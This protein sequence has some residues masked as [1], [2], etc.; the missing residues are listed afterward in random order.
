MLGSAK[1]A[2]FVA[3][4][5][6]PRARAFYEGTLGLRVVT[7]DQF[8]IAFDCDGVELR[9]QKLERVVPQSFTALGWHVPDIRAAV[10]ALSKRGVAFE[11]YAYLEQDD[12]GIW[13]A[14]GGTRVA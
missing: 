6:A 11:R 8:A 14:P 3:T 9:V 7:D 13:T 4:A 1:L 2:A 5:D 12:L 10:A